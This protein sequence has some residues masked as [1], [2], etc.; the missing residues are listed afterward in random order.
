MVVRQHGAGSGDDAAL[1]GERQVLRQRIERDPGGV[2]GLLVWVVLDGEVAAGGA[3][4]EVVDELVDPVSAD[5]EPVVDAAECGDD[6]AVH[7]GFLGDFAAGRLRGCLTEFQVAFRQAP[8]EPAGP[9][10]ARD[11]RHLE[12][13]R[14]EV[15]HDAARG[16]LL[17]GVRTHRH[18]PRLRQWSRHSFYCIS[19]T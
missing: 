3:Q 19:A 11:D 2:D 6:I 1:I 16:D 12:G 7:A 13:G 4:Q 9:V 5:G 18:D 17:H 14:I 10:D 15:D 8:L